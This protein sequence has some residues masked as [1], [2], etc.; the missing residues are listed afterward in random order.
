M[1]T[2]LRN[3]MIF[4][5]REHGGTYAALSKKYGISASSVRRIYED[6]KKRREVQKNEIFVALHAV[7]DDDSRNIRIF[8]MLKRCKVLTQEDFLLL[9]PREYSKFRDCGTVSSEVIRLA[10]EYIRTSAEEVDYISL[11]KF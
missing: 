10:Q 6:E 2:K 11:E 3:E 9:A 7:N 4:E 1:E 5:E 8:N